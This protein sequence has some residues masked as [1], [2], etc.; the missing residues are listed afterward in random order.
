MKKIE[1]QKKQ[2]QTPP[3]TRSKAKALKKIA[4]IFSQTFSHRMHNAHAVG[5]A[6]LNLNQNQQRSLVEQCN[7][8]AAQILSI[9]KE[10]SSP[11]SFLC[12]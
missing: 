12:A 1:Q 2:H 5:K 3:L 6:R 10:K 8:V 7:H 11:P 4:P 9:Q